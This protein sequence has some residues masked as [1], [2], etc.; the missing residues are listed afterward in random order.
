M[1]PC[2]FCGSRSLSFGRTPHHPRIPRIVFVMCDIC[3]Y[4]G[5][6]ARTRLG[7]AVLWNL[8]TAT[9]RESI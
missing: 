8:D 5:K 6:S 7:A 1:K 4:Y 3:H 2:P 9:K